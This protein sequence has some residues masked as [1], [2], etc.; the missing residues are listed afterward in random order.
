[1]T[2]GSEQAIKKLKEKRKITLDE[3]KIL[4]SKGLI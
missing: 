1:M 3:F 4:K 2:I